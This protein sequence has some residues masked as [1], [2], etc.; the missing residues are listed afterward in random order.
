MSNRPLLEQ[1]AFLAKE[2]PKRKAVCFFDGDTPCVLTFAQFYAGICEAGSHIKALGAKK[3]DRIVLWGENSVNYL[4]AYFGILWASGTVVPID[5]QLS[6]EKVA[7]ILRFCDSRC[8]IAASDTIKDFVPPQGVSLLPLCDFAFTRSTLSHQPPPDRE[9][10]VQVII[11][12]SGTTGEPKGVVLHDS[13]ILANVL[14]I[15]QTKFI[16][17]GESI[18][19]MLPY[20]HAYSLTASVIMP[21]YAGMFIA[22][23]PSLKAED[24]KKTM[25]KFDPTIMVAVP[26]LLRLLVAGITR[27]LEN[28]GVIAGIMRWVF[29]MSLR[30]E[31]NGRFN[32]YKFLLRPVRRKIGKNL[33]FVVSGGAKL[34]DDVS[35]SLSALGYDV[36]EGYGLSETSPILT[37]NP[38]GEARR[39]TVGLPLPSV[40]I[41]LK[42]EKDGM[43]EVIARGPNVFS[44]YFK[45]PDLTEAVFHDGWFL[46]GDLGRFDREGYLIIE[47][48]VNEMI[49]TEGGKNIFPEDIEAK[50][51][52]SEY[53]TEC[54][55]M[56]EASPS[57]ERR[58]ALV[59]VPDTAVFRARGIHEY[60]NTIRFEVTEISKHMPSYCRPSAI[61]A[62]S[63]ELPKTRLGK[64]RRHLVPKLISQQP[65][66]EDEPEASAE[67]MSEVTAIIARYVKRDAV[68]RNQHLEIDLGLD[69]LGRMDLYS[70]L[71][72]ELQVDV[73]Q[74]VASEA[75]TVGEVEELFSDPKWGKISSTTQARA[76]RLSVFKLAL[77]FIADPCIRVYLKLKLNYPSPKLHSL[78]VDTP[79]IIAP[80]HASLLDALILRDSLARPTRHR[81]MYLS[82]GKYFDGFPLNI[83][84]WCARIVVIGKKNPP[85]I[86]FR[87]L[88]DGLKQGNPVVIFPEGERTPDGRLQQ[89]RHGAFR[90]ALASRS[91][92]VPVAIKGV[93]GFMSRGGEPHKNPVMVEFGERIDTSKLVDSYGSASPA[94]LEEMLADE[95]MKRVRALLGESD[96]NN[97][98]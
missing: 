51:N 79:L 97:R 6:G 30:R 29:N 62:Y 95:W 66:I 81:A 18:L 71:S 31:K 24:L 37:L 14:D 94:E 11:F 52:A 39:G 16:Q 87:M 22:V 64:L 67:T 83:I 69:S 98:S 46:T 59:A 65:E 56:Q 68:K 78:P 26:R 73:P 23:C 47:G 91:P 19:S 60:L 43:G 45:R 1:L 96:E 72:T 35:A 28:G 74:E 50:F 40:E 32:P 36:Y 17:Q 25:L 38:Y 5:P 13:N 42:D 48:R 82:I 58:L 34:D 7:D 21:L 33:K 49:V 53:I 4:F 76:P 27:G 8:L 44:G 89:P 92:V 61:Y 80:N 90:L 54:C 12:T 57:G 20:F 3:G 55:L 15:M 88:E 70:Y 77:Q 9:G 85:A 10:A 75:H 93:F 84:A 2:H 41:A 86:A 63:G